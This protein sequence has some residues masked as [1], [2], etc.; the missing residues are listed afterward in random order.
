MYCFITKYYY[1]KLCLI[2]DNRGLIIGLALVMAVGVYVGYTLTSVSGPLKC[3]E[4]TC[5]DDTLALPEDVSEPEDLMQENKKAEEPEPLG[6]SENNSAEND[7]TDSNETANEIGEPEGSIRGM[8]DAILELFWGEG[9]PECATEKD[10]LA[11]MEERYPDL[12]IMMY[13]VNA[14]EDNLKLFMERCDEMG[15]GC[16]NVPVTIIGNTA[17]AKFR[18]YEGD[19][20]YHKQEKAFV[21]YRN[22][23][24]TSIMNELGI[25]EYDDPDG[26]K[27][28][29]RLIASTDKEIYYEKGPMEIT[30]VIR[31]ERDVN[32]CYVATRGVVG[33]TGP[34]VNGREWV[35]LK[36]GENKV[37]FKESA[38]RCFGCGGFKPGVYPID[39]WLE[40]DEEIIESI[41]LRIKIEDL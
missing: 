13:E 3:E 15:L 35:H 38:P 40:K 8:K 37:V 16:G 25:L 27:D 4:L 14:D 11:E 41:A 5:G 2:M 10:F 28:G 39:V 9:C 24:E 33:G 30:A 6:L 20:T 21:G 1:K 32:S 17:F 19:F 29:I 31:S 12:E 22:Q 26:W 18:D 34:Y 23:I 36:R 7:T